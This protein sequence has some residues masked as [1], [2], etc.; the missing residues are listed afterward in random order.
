MPRAATALERAGR[1]EQA[2]R[3]LKDGAER[4]RLSRQAFAA[5]NRSVQ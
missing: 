1:H 2:L 5:T 3:T 4:K